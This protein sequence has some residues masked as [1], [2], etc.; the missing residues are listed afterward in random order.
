[1]SNALPVLIADDD[2]DD[3]LLL[4]EAFCD[5]LLPNPL[6]FAE[7]GEQLLHSLQRSSDARQPL[8]ALIL[9]DLN[10]PRL[11]GHEAL[12]ALKGDARLCRI[13]V[14]ILSTAAEEEAQRCLEAGADA[15]IGKPSS[16]SG[17]L[18]VVR[19]L[20]DHWLAT[21]ALPPEPQPS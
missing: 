3:R 18:D 21:D 17:L 19:R 9:L 5:S 8:P 4:R 13:P 10:M 7:D 12:V 2:A 16:Y 20:G 1:M 11:D 14:V 6:H 15:V